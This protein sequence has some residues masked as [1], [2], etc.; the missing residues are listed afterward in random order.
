[1]FKELI[2]VTHIVGNSGQAIEVYPESAV[3]HLDYETG[4]LQLCVEVKDIPLPNMF[5]WEAAKTLDEMNK[6]RN[7][8]ILENSL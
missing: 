2:L 3:T 4:V 6:T 1:M 5:C 7:K 8:W